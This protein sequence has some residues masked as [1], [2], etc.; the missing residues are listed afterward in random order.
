MFDIDKVTTVQ[1]G[2]VLSMSF[3]LQGMSDGVG[4]APSPTISITVPA[5]TG[6]ASPGYAVGGQ[7]S[8]GQVVDLML[9][10]FGVFIG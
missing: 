1:N 10:A 4:P 7:L 2:V 8:F 6:A 9:A 3:T 5:S